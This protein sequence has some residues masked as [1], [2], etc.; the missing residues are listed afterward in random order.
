MSGEVSSSDQDMEIEDEGTSEVSYH[1]QQFRESADR[2]P[3]KSTSGKSFLQVGSHGTIRAS[4]RSRAREPKPPRTQKIREQKF[5]SP[6]RAFH[7]DEETNAV[8]HGRATIISKPN[9]K[10]PDSATRIKMEKDSKNSSE[11]NEFEARFSTSGLTDTI[12]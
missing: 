6:T 3:L 12:K 2:S 8:F 7:P 9:F 5:G 10:V 4:S 1:M 11:V